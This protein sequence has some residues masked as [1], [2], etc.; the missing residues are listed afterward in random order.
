MK[1]VLFAMYMTATGPVDV[2]DPTLAAQQHRTIG[3][4]SAQLVS[5]RQKLMAA[6]LPRYLVCEPLKVEDISAARAEHAHK[7]QR[8]VTF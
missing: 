3:K 1:W 6:N 2:V 4:C 8:S 7:F 5:I